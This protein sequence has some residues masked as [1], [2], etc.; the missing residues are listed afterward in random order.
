MSI[1]STLLYLRAQPVRPGPSDRLSHLTTVHQRR[2]SALE[3]AFESYKYN[4]LR[5]KKYRA[6][7]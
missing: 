2:Q 3:T 7:Q 4:T 6:R 5:A 1:L